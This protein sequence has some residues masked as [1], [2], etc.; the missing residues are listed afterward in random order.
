MISET[1]SGNAPAPAKDGPRIND[2]DHH[3]NHPPDRR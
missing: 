1:F 3:Q 2:E